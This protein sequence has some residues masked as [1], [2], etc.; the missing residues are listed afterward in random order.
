MLD[1]ALLDITTALAKRA[2]KV[3]DDLLAHGVVKDIAEQVA[4]LLVVVVGVRVGVPSGLA[5][6][7]LLAPGVDGALSGLSGVRVGLVVRHGAIASVDGHGSVAGVVVAHTSAVG[8]VDGDLVVVGTETM[9]MGVGV[10]DQT[11]LKHL[12][13]RWFDTWD[14]VGGGEGYLLGLSVEV[15]GVLVQ[16]NSS[17]LLERVVAVRPD[18]GDVVDVEAVVVSV[19]DGHDLGVPCP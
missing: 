6:H 13:V 4:R 18:L 8:A 2:G 14:H 17:D 5:N 12:V 15:L 9:T 10:V 7:V 19:G 11:A 1:H 3:L 16:N